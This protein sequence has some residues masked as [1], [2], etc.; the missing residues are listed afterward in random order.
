[1]NVSTVSPDQS[2]IHQRY[3]DFIEIQSALQ[4]GNISSAQSAF[5]AFEQEVQ[6]IGQTGGSSNLFAPGSQLTKDLQNLGSALKS[7]DLGSA[8]QAFATLKQDI[9]ATGQSSSTQPAV[10]GHHHQSH[11]LIAA[12]G[13][14]SVAANANSFA[15]AQAAGAILNLHA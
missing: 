3:Q 6:K 12:N 13:V 15:S 7:A 14:E 5:A 1:M 2:T 9:Q 8:Q 4:T 10:N 11:A